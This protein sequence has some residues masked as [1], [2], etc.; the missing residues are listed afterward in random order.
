MLWCLKFPPISSH[1]LHPKYFPPAK[2]NLVISHLWLVPNRHAPAARPTSRP[3]RRRTRITRHERWCTAETA[4][5][6]RIR[7]AAIPDASVLRSQPSPHLSL[8]LAPAGAL[9]RRRTGGLPRH[10]LR[11]STSPYLTRRRARVA[12]PADTV[13][14][15]QAPI[16]IEHCSSRR[17]VKQPTP[18]S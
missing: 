2:G 11:T 10:C 15:P 7:T 4:P 3:L 18:F 14:L 6:A 16:P 8:P 17:W 5:P 1:F 12:R 9:A 13:F